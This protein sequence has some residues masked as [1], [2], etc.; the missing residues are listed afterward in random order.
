VVPLPALTLRAGDFYFSRDGQPAFLF[1]RNLA[2]YQVSHFDQLL[3]WTASGSSSFVRL[4]LDDFGMGYL[5]GG[6]VDENWARQWDRVFSLAETNGIYVLPVFSAWYDWNAGGG[7]STW[8]N[9]PLNQAKGGPVA[10]PLELFETDSSTQKL[11][12]DW[13]ETLVGRWT[14]RRNIL[15]WEVFS[16]VNLASKPSETNGIAFVNAAAARIRAADPAGRPVTASIADTGTWP[17]F[18][19]KTN[20]DF[21]NLH[22]YPTSAQLDRILVSEV[23]KSLAKYNRP[24]LIGES[25]LNAETPDSQG[26]KI[27]VAANAPLGIRHA[28][29]AGIVS[30][31]MNGRALWWEDGVGIYFSGLGFPWMSR[32]RDAELAAARFVAGVDFSGFKP[33]TSTSSPT[34]W[35]AAVGDGQMILGW[36]RDASCE[37]PDWKLKDGISGAKVTVSAPGTATNWRVDFYDV[38]DGTKILGTIFVTRQGSTLVIPLPDFKDAIAF[39]AGS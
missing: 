33:L 39:K 9:N 22:P 16:E 28:I 38:A 4:H 26:G 7:Y 19:R 30:G 24:L 13:M 3:I 14:D 35:G 27:T 1:S 25:G 37:P 34:V 18:Y 36:Y 31:A 32:Y 10:D 12:L 6:G 23:R 8:Q 15:A 21:I 20:I 29:W 5:P 2:G 11:W 17:N